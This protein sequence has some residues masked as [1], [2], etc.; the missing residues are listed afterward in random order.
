MRKVKFY[1]LAVALVPTA[2]F[3]HLVYAADSVA[4][5]FLVVQMVAALTYIVLLFVKE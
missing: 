1:F 5:A 4:T 3:A 2:V